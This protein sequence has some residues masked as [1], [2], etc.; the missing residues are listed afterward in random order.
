[1]A[2]N[3]TVELP[4]CLSRRRG[5]L[6]PAPLPDSGTSKALDASGVALKGKEDSIALRPQVPPVAKLYIFKLFLCR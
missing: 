4:G 5:M 2:P 3:I 6:P 1:M